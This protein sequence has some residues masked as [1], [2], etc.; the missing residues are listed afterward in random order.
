[1]Q[2]ANGS[3]TH[4]MSTN[5]SVC[6][7]V[8]IHVIHGLVPNRDPVIELPER[9]EVKIMIL[10]VSKDSEVLNTLIYYYTKYC[11]QEIFLFFL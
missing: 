6:S 8:F 1:M 9:D 2:N 11:L 7:Q 3:T 10:F 4:A 5:I